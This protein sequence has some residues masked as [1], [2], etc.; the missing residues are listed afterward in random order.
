MQARSTAPTLWLVVLEV[1]CCW[2]WWGVE[3]CAVLE[4]G[5]EGDVVWCP[6][7]FY[8]LSVYVSVMES[9]HEDEVV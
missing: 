1:E 4:G 5:Y 9:A 6:G 2:V 3:H 7:E 8:V